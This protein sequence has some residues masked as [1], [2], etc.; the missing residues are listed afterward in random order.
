MYLT[1]VDPKNSHVL[2]DKLSTQIPYQATAKRA[3][4][5]SDV[6][7]AHG[8]FDGESGKIIGMVMVGGHKFILVSIL[9]NDRKKH[10]Y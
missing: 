3:R 8:K 6:S 7:K 1:F 4:E 5:P 2:I 10:F 9:K